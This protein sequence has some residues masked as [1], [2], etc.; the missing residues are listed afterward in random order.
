MD[1]MN[2]EPE[3]KPVGSGHEFDFFDDI[4]KEAE[5]SEENKRIAHQEQ[6]NRASKPLR[7]PKYSK[8]TKRKTF[9][10]TVS[11]IVILSLI[12]AIAMVKTSSPTLARV[13][14]PK[15]PGIT[16]PANPINKTV[17]NSPTTSVP[18][19]PTTIK[20]LTYLEP[21]SPNCLW[22]LK[23]IEQAWLNQNAN[24]SPTPDPNSVPNTWP[25]NSPQS[26]SSPISAEYDIYAFM[27]ATGVIAAHPTAEN[28]NELMLRF[29]GYN[30][31]TTVQNY[32]TQNV[33]AAQQYLNANAVAH[34]MPS[35]WE[36]IPIYYALDA[37]LQLTAT[38]VTT[39]NFVPASSV[40]VTMCVTTTVRALVPSFPLSMISSQIPP[41]GTTI[42]QAQTTTMIWLGTF[43]APQSESSN[44]VKQC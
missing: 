15:T 30:P 42:S 4:K 39:T 37:A 6:L 13:A 40:T 32:L 14:V 7:Q 26:P 20:V 31:P 16:A 43:W 38:K 22:T 17:S 23:Q 8:A 1:N 29:G 21:A 18:N 2:S 19:T 5:I 3:F 11:T 33:K 12:V 27:I 34:G 9:L 10:L 35:Q 25:C 28:L 44:I 36:N 24:I 41:I